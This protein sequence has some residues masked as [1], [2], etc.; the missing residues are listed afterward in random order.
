V[1]IVHAADIHLDSPLV[2]LEKYEGCP[3]DALRG[4]TRGAFEALVSA[5]L[6]ERADLVLLAGDLY[7]GAWKDYATGLF[8]VRQMVR[9]KEGGIPVVMVRGNH[10]AESEI[11][12]KLRLPDNVAD[13]STSEPETRIFE[14]LGVAVHG[15]GFV[16]RD[17]TDDLARRYPIPAAGAFNVGLLHTALWGR[18]GHEL[19]APTSLGVL[20]D[21]CYDYWALGHVHRR[22]VV[23]RDPFIVFPGNLQGRHVRETGPKGATFITV[24][25]GRIREVEHRVLDVVRWADVDVAVAEDDSLDAALERVRTELVRVAAEAGDRTVGARVTLSGR[26]AS[27]GLFADRDGEIVAG[28]RAAAIE[29]AGEQIWIGSA[30]SRIRPAIDVEALAAAAA[31]SADPVAHL[32]GSIRELSRDDERLTALAAELGDLADKLPEELRKDPSAAFFDSPEAMRALVAD[33][34]DLLL[35]RIALANEP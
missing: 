21:K 19:Y 28:V 15:Q 26:S 1:L 31:G 30:R 20:K 27:S 14:E 6:G 4:A 22:E 17:L 24:D 5:A 16:R 10:D 12:R 34:E 33:V 25:G 2:G 11:T 13:L 35:G 3:V 7:D 8:F 23:A 18:E 29:A 32:V 9:L